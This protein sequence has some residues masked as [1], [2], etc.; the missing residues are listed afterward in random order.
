MQ[1]GSIT[2]IS[3]A[4][5]NFHFY[6]IYVIQTEYKNA[7]IIIKYK[8][9]N[10]IHSYVYEDMYSPITEVKFLRS[11]GKIIFIE[12]FFSDNYFEIYCS[13]KT[14]TIKNKINIMNT[15]REAHP[16]LYKKYINE[17][18][19]E[20]IGAGSDNNFQSASIAKTEEYALY[21]YVFS[22]NFS[23]TLSKD[24]IGKCLDGTNIK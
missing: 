4:N 1:I 14:R 2:K 6:N 15:D 11:D 19:S 20:F 12:T 9:C 3:R 13:E 8:I 21:Y 22:L 5:L 16:E 10:V 7:I 18:D 24:D 17:D 23:N